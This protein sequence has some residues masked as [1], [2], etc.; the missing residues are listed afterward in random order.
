MLSAVAVT[1]GQTCSVMVTMLSQPAVLRM[2]SE[3][4]PADTKCMPKVS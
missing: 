3:S 2:V 4:V 1:L